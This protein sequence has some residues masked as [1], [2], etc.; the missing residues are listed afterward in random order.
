[1]SLASE[2]MIK[3]NKRQAHAFQV[4]LNNLIVIITTT[5][6]TIR[7]EKISSGSVR[8]VFFCFGI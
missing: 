5:E 6:P 4:F 7:T 8:S 1:M 2:P 3:E